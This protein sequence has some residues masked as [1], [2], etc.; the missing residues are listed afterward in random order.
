MKITH[1]CLAGL[2]MDGWGYQ[3]NLIAKYHV[4]FGYDVTVITNRWVYDQEGNYVKTD[5]TEETDRYGVKIIRIPIKGDKPYT[6]K[7]KR[8]EGLYETLCKTAPDVIFLHSTQIRDVEDI[9]R[10]KKEHQKTKL[11][12]DNHC[13][14]S[15]SA[16][17]FLSK[18]ILHGIL[19]KRSTLKLNPYTEKFY[20]VLPARVDFLTERYKLPKER[21][22]LL[23][24][25]M[26]DEKAQEADK[27]EIKAQIRSRFGYTQE[28]FVVITGGKIDH[29]KRQTLLLMEAVK[30]IDNPHLK[31]LVF[32]SVVEDMKA[33]LN[34]LCD[35][36][37][38]ITYIGWV[39]AD[40]TYP[41]FAASDLAVFPGRHSV[42]WEQVAGQGIPM[43]VKHWEGTTHVDVGGNVE[44]LYQ[45][46]V[47]EIQGVLERLMT[48]GKEYNEM[49][50]NARE[51][52]K[53]V[54]SYREI[55]KRAIGQKSE[56]NSVKGR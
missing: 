38:R 23:V 3:D 9:I 36:D 30:K 40:D 33:A 55:A 26:D 20:G 56:D 31:L 22:E 54:F 46:S 32:G 49:L 43:A 19:W 24:M 4:S 52:G 8:Y 15:N 44:F 29:A 35:S 25:G 53:K 47:E 14:Y 41:Y 12:A 16:T 28:D 18:Y 45:D 50:K 51:K 34:K 39:N 11:Y 17:N 6:Y 48:K 21:V 37:G 42:M 1:I 10:Y 2:F 7:L 13:D 27:P 5:K